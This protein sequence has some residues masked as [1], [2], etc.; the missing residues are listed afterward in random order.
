MGFLGWPG[1]FVF[2]FFLVVFSPLGLEVFFRS[3]RSAFLA[4]FSFF[5]AACSPSLPLNSS[6]ESE[7]TETG[8]HK[9]IVLHSVADPGCFSGI[10]IFS[11]LDAGSEF[12]P[13]RIPDPHQRSIVTQKNGF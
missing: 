11:I 4:A 2:F 13:S 3:I 9:E 5:L 8:R 10:R 1:S 7:P 12:F 6:P